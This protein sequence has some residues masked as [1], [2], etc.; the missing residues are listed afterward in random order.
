MVR[1]ASIPSWPFCTQIFLKLWKCEK[2]WLLLLYYFPLFMVA[3]MNMCLSGLLW[4]GLHWRK[5]VLSEF[6]ASF[7]WRPRYLRLPA[8]IWNKPSSVRNAFPLMG[9]VTSR[10]PPPITPVDPLLELH[11]N[12][13]LPSLSPS[14]ESDPHCGLRIL[15]LP[16]HFPSQA[17]FPINSLYV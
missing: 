14:Q 3:A 5:A 11:C 12:L 15:P 6:T 7:A 9:E 1:L 2:G 4:G 17:C 13:K 8:G 10:P 16:S